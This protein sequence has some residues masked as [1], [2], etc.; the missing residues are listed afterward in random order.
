MSHV[1][2]I[3]VALTIACSAFLMSGCG[4]CSNNAAG[5]ITSCPTL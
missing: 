2:R 1:T 4:A 5:Q 3:F